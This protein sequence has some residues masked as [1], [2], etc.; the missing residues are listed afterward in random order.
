MIVGRV[1][2]GLACLWMLINAL[3]MASSPRAWFRLPRW[4]R[5]QG[6]LTEEKYTSGWGAIQVRIAGAALI[7][8][9]AWAI[10]DVFFSVR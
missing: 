3:F 5:A 1:L 8:I 6:P 2:A 10:R 9:L 4:L 7:G